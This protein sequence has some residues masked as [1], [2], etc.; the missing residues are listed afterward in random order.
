MQLCV[1]ALAGDLNVSGW[2]PGVLYIE[3]RGDTHR[4]LQG[5]LCGSVVNSDSVP[6]EVHESPGFSTSSILLF[7]QFLKPQ[8]ELHMYV[9]M[10]M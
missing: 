1:A 10:Y 5:R 9:Y 6:L 3:P 8:H 2:G 4:L 7:F